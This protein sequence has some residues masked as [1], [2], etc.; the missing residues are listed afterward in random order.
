MIASFEAR[1]DAHLE[2]NGWDWRDTDYE[3]PRS[4]LEAT[5][6]FF[7]SWA[8]AL[9]FPGSCTSEQRSSVVAA[10]SALDEVAKRK[11]MPTVFRLLLEAMQPVV[12]SEDMQCDTSLGSLYALGRALQ[13]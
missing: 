7:T 9:G 10:V 2:D 4:F 6:A 5:A 11:I 12:A 1:Y 3:D 8:S 13:S